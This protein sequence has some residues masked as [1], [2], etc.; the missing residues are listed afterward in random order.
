MQELERRFQ[1]TLVERF[2]KRAYLTQAGEKLIVHARQ[3]L[4]DDAR[5][6][7]DMRK[8]DDG[9]LGRVRVGTSSTVLMYALPPILRQLKTAHP[10]LEIAL[11]TGLTATTLEMLKTNALDL[12]LCALPVDDPGFEVAS[13]FEDELVAILPAKMTKM[14]KK[15]TPEFLSRCH[16][17]FV[18]RWGSGW[19]MPDPRRSR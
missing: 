12:G 3:L 19:H 18:A 2:G 8:L 7:M 1:V 10:Q 16:R 5:A 15:V 14:P 13:L 11:K 6:Q 9:W 4:E 17:R